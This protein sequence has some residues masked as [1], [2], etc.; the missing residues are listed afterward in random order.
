MRKGKILIHLEL[1]KYYSLII[2]LNGGK[3]MTEVLQTKDPLFDLISNLIRDYR[4]L[5]DEGISMENYYPTLFDH[6]PQFIWFADKEGKRIYFNKAWTVFTGKQIKDHV[7]DGWI[8]NISMNEQKFI[9]EKYYQS[10][11]LNQ[12]FK[13]EYHIKN[14]NGE[15]RTIIDYCNPYKGRNGDLVGYIGVSFDITEHTEFEKELVKENREIYTSLFDNNHAAMILVEPNTGKIF[16]ANKA[17]CDFY[18]YEKEKLLNKK[19]SDINMLTKDDVKEKMSLIDTGKNDRFRLKHRLANGEIK[20]IEAHTGL[21][22]SQGKP[23]YYGIIYDI[24][25]RIKSE[26]A[27][28]LAYS[29]LDQIFSTTANGMRVIGLDHKI[30]RIN[31]TMLKILGVTR[32]EAIGNKCYDVFPGKYCNTNKCPIEIIGNGEK[33]IE[34]EAEKELPNGSVIPC[35]ITATPFMDHEGQVVGV[36]EDFVDISE[37]KRTEE[38][39]KFVAYHDHLTHLPNRLLFNEKLEF[40]INHITDSDTILAVMFLDLDD[41]KYINDTYGHS[42]GDEVLVKVAERLKRI[43]GKNNVVARIGGDE[44]TIL[45]KDK[46]NIE[47]VSL[48]AQ[49]LLASFQKPI[50]IKDIEFYITS[51]I[52]ISIH[53]TDGDDVDTITKHAD[54]AMY[55]AKDHGKNSVEFFSRRKKKNFSNRFFLESQLRHA[56]ERKELKLYYQPQ[57]NIETGEVIGFEALLRWENSSLGFVSPVDFIPVAEEIGLIN[58]IGSWVIYEAAKKIKRWQEKGIHSLRI[59]VNISVR[60]LQQTNFLEQVDEVLRKTGITPSNL[61]FEI[62]ESIAL[63][64]LE[65]NIMILGKLKKMGIQISLDD[66]GTGYSSLSYLKMLPIDNLKIDKSFV[67]NLTHDSSNK[68]IASA[69]IAMAHSLNLKVIAEGVEEKEQ[70][71]FLLEQKCDFYQGFL[72]SKPIPQREINKFFTIRK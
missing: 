21:I 5:D 27:L 71:D 9:E 50:V 68:A 60:Q 12:S 39:L 38:K 65:Y 57:V 11:K 54:I 61:E 66:F 56:L 8:N 47:E 69:I 48:F 52:G 36:V 42:T 31:D 67:Q 7:N 51:S 22:T 63:T 14:V 35:I 40:E 72:F 23:L 20:D 49:K 43:V 25:D 2:I 26:E 70:L 53:P 44:F 32:E 1:I 64:N 34:Y 30:I 29:E 33:R 28:K 6:F 10:I 59:A 62:T 41:F 45:L 37:R 17:A 13:M 15:Y 58:K 16:D 46:S 3:C 4:I 18:G 55:H 19:V 24:S